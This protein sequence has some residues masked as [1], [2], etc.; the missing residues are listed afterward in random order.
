M[1]LSLIRTIFG[2]F[3]VLFLPGY[4]FSL[5]LFIKLQPVE[6]FCVSIGLSIVIVAFLA[7]FLTGLGYLFQIKGINSASVWISLTIICILL[8]ILIFGRYIKRN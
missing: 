2:I 5:I 4:L 1:I 7:F 6:R 8:T 3:F